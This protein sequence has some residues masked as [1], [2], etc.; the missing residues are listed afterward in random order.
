MKGY[1]FSL[2]TLL[3]TVVVVGIVLWLYQLGR[4]GPP[5]LFTLAA[6]FVLIVLPVLLVGQS[7]AAKIITSYLAAI[8]CFGGLCFFIAHL[9]L[10]YW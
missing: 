6:F 10:T 2:R 7:D 9:M 8:L 3:A 5:M 1:Q 4:L